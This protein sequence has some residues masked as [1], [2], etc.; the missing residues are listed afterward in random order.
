M[1]RSASVG[2]V[3]TVSNYRELGYFLTVRINHFPQLEPGAAKGCEISVGLL[4]TILLAV[5][6]DC[7]NSDKLI[8]QYDDDDDDRGMRELVYKALWEKLMMI[9]PTGSESEPQ[10]N[11][12]CPPELTFLFLLSYLKAVV[13]V[14]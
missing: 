7:N 8:G 1:N 5:V 14:A 11:S 6:V 13:V 3:G 4:G 12:K 10:L 2:K 9:E